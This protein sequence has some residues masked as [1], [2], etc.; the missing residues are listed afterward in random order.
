MFRRTEP[1]GSTARHEQEPE[2]TLVPQARRLRRAAKWAA[3]LAVPASLVT[4]GAVY[5]HD[6]L[7][8]PVLVVA[9]IAVIMVFAVV[10]VPYAGYT[11]VL[12]RLVDKGI[13]YVNSLDDVQKLQK[14]ATEG[15]SEFA[16]LSSR[17]SRPPAA[18]GP[19]VHQRLISPEPAATTD[20]V[21][22]TAV[23]ATAEPAP[24]VEPAERAEPADD[25][26]NYE[27]DSFMARLTDG[28]RGALW[29][30]GRPCAYGPDETLFHEGQR[31]EYVVII[32]TGRARVTVLHEGAE[33]A[34]ARRGPGDLVGERAISRQRDRSAT[35]VA[36]DALTGL[37]I[38]AVDFLAFIN[39][40]ERVIDVL[41]QQMFHRMTE[42]GATPDLDGQIHTVLMTDIVGFSH[43]RRDDGDRSALV[44]ASYKML[45]DV[46]DQAGIGWSRCHVE[47]RGDGVLLVPPARVRTAVVT[48]PLMGM[49]ANRVHQHNAR[50]SPQRRFQL[51]A[52][53]D[54]GPITPHG[55]R[56]EGETIIT[57][58][59]LLA[60]DAVR[61][62]AARP[63]TDLGFI[64]SRFVYEKVV[65]HQPRPAEYREVP[66]SVKYLE[67]RAWLRVYG[68]RSA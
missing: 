37:K 18:P 30:L 13:L 27:P 29:D 68:R 50:V 41:E 39:H 16:V 60:A 22:I 31:A 6:R 61:A 36:I 14:S 51:R 63:G 35:V 34:I 26:P 46:F 8:G 45:A 38:S 58:A 67:D 56:V 66:V 19:P 48:R 12:L 3:A 57:T 40:D 17:A 23:R 49:L 43:P 62:A 32:L 24:E 15:F 1:I 54:V 11:I 55:L 52:A 42:P 10:L 59:R 47:D 28:Q 7:S 33:E 21:E 65:R 2:I 4:G 20:A 53:L 64:V 25:P 44:A 5:G 9:A